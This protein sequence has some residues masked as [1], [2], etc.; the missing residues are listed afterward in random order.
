MG[1]IFLRLFGLGEGDASQQTLTLSVEPGT[2]V[3]ALWEG[4]SR[5]APP[6]AKMA[7][8]EPAG[9]LALLN[10]RPLRTQ[11]EWGSPVC[12]GDTVVY[13]PKAFGG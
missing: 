2:T 1:Q 12:D 3:Y 9:L 13:M 6:G 11:A 4:L 5:E 7:T 10:G 8:I